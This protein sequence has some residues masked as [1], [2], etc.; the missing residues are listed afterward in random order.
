MITSLAYAKRLRRKAIMLMRGVWAQADPNADYVKVELTYFL[1]AR[2][3]MADE[4]ISE[5]SERYQPP[6]SKAV[7]TDGSGYYAALC[8]ESDFGCNLWEGNSSVP[9]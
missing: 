2:I 6:G 9:A 4:I 7:V 3:K 8:V 5:D 1:C